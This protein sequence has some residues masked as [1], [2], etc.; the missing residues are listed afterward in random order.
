MS[1]INQ[2]LK[3]AQ[4][5][6]QGPP[7]EPAPTLHFRPV[8]P[9]QR[10]RHSLG[11]V[12]PIALAIIALLLLFLVWQWVQ[13]KNS[14]PVAAQQ[15]VPATTPVQAAPPAVATQ[16]TPESPVANESATTA[17]ASVPEPE[18]AAPAPAPEPATPQPPKPPPPRLQS[19]VF[20]PARPSAM[21][22]GRVVFLGDK[23]GDM[24]LTA[25]DQESVTLTGGGQTN[26]LTLGQ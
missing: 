24:R 15:A 20:N 25:L 12:V 18:P 11:V 6:Q 16:S 2:A 14:L 3:R 9:A 5:A 26:V 19:I 13:R 23:V 10:A 1:L 4:E 8:E 17:P 7:P 21:I 22:N